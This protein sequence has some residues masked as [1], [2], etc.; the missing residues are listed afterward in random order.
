MTTSYPVPPPPKDHLQ[1]W[2]S[3]RTT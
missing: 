1:R 3:C 2:G